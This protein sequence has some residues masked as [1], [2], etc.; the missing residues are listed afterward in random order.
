MKVTGARTSS[1]VMVRRSGR[2]ELSMKDS[3]S[4]GRS[5]AKELLT[6]MISHN[7]WESLKITISVAKECTCGVMGESM[8]ESGSLT[9]WMD[10]G[11]ILIFTTL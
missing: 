11:K 8:M 10:Q 1:M 3:I 4:M 2:M 7:M 6:G 5:M 9:R